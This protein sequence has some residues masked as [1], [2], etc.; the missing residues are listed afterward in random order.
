MS[1]MP[2]VPVIFVIWDTS[3]ALLHIPI[4][5]MKLYVYKALRHMY[6]HI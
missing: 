2:F 5:S 1:I 3:S 4:T 6:P